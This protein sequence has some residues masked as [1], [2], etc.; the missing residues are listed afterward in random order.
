MKSKKFKLTTPILFLVFNR[1]EATK[2]VFEEIKK[3]KPTTLFISSDGPRTNYPAEKEVV[4]KIR[5]DLLASINWPCTVKTLFREKNLGC[6]YAAS[7]AIDWFFDNVEQGIVLEDDCLPS[8]GFF[9]FCQKILNKYK[10][11]QRIMHVSGTNVEG[12][13]STNET[14]FFTKVYNAWG[15]AT[16]RRAWKLYDIDVKQ[17]PKFKKEGWMRDFSR[18][19]LD[20]V[21][22][23][24]GMDNI[25]NNKL[26]TWD[27]QWVFSCMLN[28]GLSIIPKVNM[29]KN[30]GF[31]EK[32]THMDRFDKNKLL[33]LRTLPLP[34]KENNFMI[35]S[36]HYHHSAARFFHKGR[37]AK[38]ILKILIKIK[39]TVLR[40]E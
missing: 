5:K 8:Q 31:D 35:E 22:N 4:L 1:P 24:R 14:Y 13:S 36:R 19:Y 10:D 3:A 12:V 18:S 32:G 23:I 29:I 6:K 15:W 33:E 37:I 38:K 21:E 27:Y 26:D 7:G 28:N 17:W 16:W 34:F 20:S 9:K 30:I 11:D 39:K 40:R 2:T 25:Y